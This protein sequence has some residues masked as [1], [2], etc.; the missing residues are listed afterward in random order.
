MGMKCIHTIYA[1]LFLIVVSIVPIFGIV[2]ETSL[3]LRLGWQTGYIVLLTGLGGIEALILLASTALARG[4]MKLAAQT[5]IPAVVMIC[6]L[7]WCIA[8]M[9][10]TPT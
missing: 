3:A 1:A 4:Q 8:H 10:W 5:G 9:N 2:M 6:V 7:L